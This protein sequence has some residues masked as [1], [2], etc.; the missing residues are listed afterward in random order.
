MAWMVERAD[1]CP[2]GLERGEGKPPCGSREDSVTPPDM[3][4]LRNNAP[5]DYG[6]PGAHLVRPVLSLD[7]R[8][9][10]CL[11]AQGSDATLLR[12]L[13]VVAWSARST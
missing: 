5:M 12:W 11:T 3:F 1:R 4:S 13:R 8:F 7:R 9:R 2:A 6:C 10:R